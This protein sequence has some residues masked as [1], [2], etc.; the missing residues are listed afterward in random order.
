[1]NINR[2]KLP[3]CLGKYVRTGQ[4]LRARYL[5]DCR[6]KRLFR[7]KEFLDRATAIRQKDMANQQCRMS[8]MS[9]NSLGGLFSLAGN[10]FW[11]LVG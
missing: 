1:M 9:G 8:G 3:K 5:I 4:F 6:K 11:R 2:N 7:M 10:S